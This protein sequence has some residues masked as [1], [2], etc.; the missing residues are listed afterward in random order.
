MNTQYAEQLAD[1]RWQKKRLK[2]LD[3]DKWTCTK[4]GD[5]KTQLE[6]HHKK[7]KGRKAWNTP[8]RD[9]KTHC[10]LCHFEETMIH[11][12]ERHQLKPH[13]EKLGFSFGNCKGEKGKLDAIVELIYRLSTC[14][15]QQVKEFVL[16]AEVEAAK[17]L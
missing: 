10:S 2:V 4:C 16:K 7:Y 12:F 9:L 8:L 15:T 11:M 13:I 14:T 5:K 17:F 1:P 6:V 3:R